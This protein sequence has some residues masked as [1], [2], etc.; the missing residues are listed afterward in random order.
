MPS[1]YEI[2]ELAADPRPAYQ[3]EKSEREYGCLI[4]GYNVR[5]TVTDRD[6][7]IA[8]CDAV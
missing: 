1:R 6:A 8:S 7:L 4:E 5:W 3:R 2:S